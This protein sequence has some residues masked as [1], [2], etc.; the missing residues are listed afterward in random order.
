MVK[1]TFKN[2]VTGT[3]VV[4]FEYGNDADEN[5]DMKY[6]GQDY[7]NTAYQV[8]AKDGSNKVKPN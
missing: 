3:Y 6:N 2:F 4:R 7:K 5:V 1:Y 8:G